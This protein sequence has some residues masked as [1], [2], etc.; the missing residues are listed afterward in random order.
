MLKTFI[1]MTTVGALIGWLTN[2]IAIK[3]LFRPIEPIK[4]PL[5]PFSFQGLMPKRRNEIAK[6]IG[7]TVQNE[8]LSIEEIMDELI[9]GM[10]KTEII[11]MLQSYVSKIVEEKMPSMVPTMFKGMIVKYVYD[12]VADEGENMINQ[13]SDKVIHHATEKI[14]ISEMIEAKINAFPMA[15]LERLVLDI[16]KKELKHIEVLGGVIGLLIGVL[17]WGIVTFL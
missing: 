8:L 9:E 17:Q 1:I 10:D 12:L 13:L 16:A 5:L 15:E 4:L 6:S 7:E 14:N 3:L 11:K 2:V